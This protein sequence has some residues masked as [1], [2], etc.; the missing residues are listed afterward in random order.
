[1]RKSVGKNIVGEQ[2]IMTIGEIF[3][4]LIIFRIGNFD[5]DKWSAPFDRC[6]QAFDNVIVKAFGIDFDNRGIYIER[7][8]RND[9][10]VE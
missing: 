3:I 2:N 5:H 9:I 6:F 7:I 1:M 10:A 8:Y 4:D